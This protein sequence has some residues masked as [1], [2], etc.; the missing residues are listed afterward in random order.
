LGS[1]LIGPP[2]HPQNCF[3]KEFEI[4]VRWGM[5]P[6]QAIMAGTA[7]SAEALGM[8]D[9]IGTVE[10]GKL[11]DLIAMK[12]SPLDDIKQ[13]QDVKFVMQGGTIIRNETVSERLNQ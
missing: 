1:D 5:T 13:L 7:V 6:M 10:V 11:A 8:Q 3:A 9:D 2:T 12:K 4:A